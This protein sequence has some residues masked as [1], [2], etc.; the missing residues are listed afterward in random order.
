M[1]ETKKRRLAGRIALITGAS[2]GLGAAVAER[3]AAEGAQLI[4]VARTQGGLEETDDRVRAAGGQATLV[5][6]DL[7]RFDEIDRMAAAVAQRFGR[8]DILVGNA[9]QLPYLTPVGHLS[10]KDWQATLDLNLTANWRLIRAFDQGLRLSDAGR[11]IM[12]TSGAAAGAFAYWAAYAA[13]KAA[14]ETL[15][16]SYANET[17]Q[18][19]IRAN[20]LDPG[21][22]RT[23][24]R[25]QAFPGE[26]PETLRPPEEVAPV[27]VNLAEA[28]CTLHGQVARAYG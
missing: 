1:A 7:T 24:M 8:L 10:P 21:A 9:A 12:V 17:K 4:L 19:K 13:S 22:V 18:T 23:A 15:V 26:N 11:V 25:A 27:F 2:R 6:L 16:A 5:P 14:L 20:L 28:S 3:F